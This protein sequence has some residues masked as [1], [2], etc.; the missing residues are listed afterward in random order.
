MNSNSPSESESDPDYVCEPDEGLKKCSDYIENLLESFYL[1][2]IGPDRSRNPKSIKEVMDDVR[3]ILVAVGATIDLSIVFDERATTLRDKYLMGHCVNRGTKPSSIRKYLY[4][5][6]DFCTFLL[7]EK[8]SVEGVSFDD[9]L[10]VKLRVQMWWKSYSSKE[11]GQRHVRN[12]QDFEML[13]T[14]EQVQIYEKSMHATT[15]KNL[16]AE[17]KIANRSISQ[18]EYCCMR[19]DLYTIIHFGHGHRSG[20]SANLLM[21]E[22]LKAKVISTVAT[23]GSELKEISVWNHK[24]FNTYGPAKISLRPDEFLWLKTFIDVARSQINSAK[25]ENVFLSWSGNAMKSG[26]VSKRLHTLWCNAGIFEDHAIPKNLSCNIIRKSTST[27]LRES[28]TGCYQEAADLMAHSL[29]TAEGHYYLCEQEKS[30]ARAGGVIRKYFY[31]SSTTV[32]P[33]KYRKK[34]SEG[35]VQKLQKEFGDNLESLRLVD[36]EERTPTISVDASPQQIYN[37]VRSMARYSPKA[38]E[39]KRAQ[40][41]V[42]HENNKIIYN[43]GDHTKYSVILGPKLFNLRRVIYSSP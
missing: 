25:V 20:V 14:P 19:D 29:K 10:T 3:R 38:P 11:K 15:A 2:L 24:T 13:V 9:I 7:T 26:D 40:L 43:S 1:Y 21:S 16:F 18:Q 8:C 6:I 32:T 30:A 31:E 4:Y 12:A 35:E 39:K 34:W 42:S 27:G 5:F 17:L 36:V 22:Y 41:T 37:K 28:N 33:P 23:D